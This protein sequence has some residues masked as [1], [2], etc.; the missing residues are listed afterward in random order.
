MPTEAEWEKAARGSSD[1]R[2]YP[3]GDEVPDATYLNADYETGDTTRVGSYPA[4]ASPYG[5]MDM[6][7][8]VLEETSDWYL[9]S[10]YSVSPASSGRA[11]APCVIDDI[12]PPSVVEGGH[13]LPGRASGE[14]QLIDV[15]ESAVAAD[16]VTCKQ[17]GN[18]G[19]EHVVRIA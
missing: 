4:G 17:R 8:N 13:P 1:T 14:N 18:L 19:Q 6:A 3:W 12:P 2:I 10:Y 5:V 11:V 16:A 15:R 7:G 9:E